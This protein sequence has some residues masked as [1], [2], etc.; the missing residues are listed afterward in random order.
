MLA[1][2]NGLTLERLI[3]PS[4]VDD[5]LYAETQAAILHHATRSPR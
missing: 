4:E 1:I 2:A 3:A 5:A